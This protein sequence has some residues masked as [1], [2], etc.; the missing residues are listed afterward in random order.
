[1]SCSRYNAHAEECTGV[2]QATQA[3]VERTKVHQAA[4]VVNRSTFHCPLCPDRNMDRA[5][6]L[7]HFE[8]K[9]RR[10]AGVC[11]ICA[12]MPWGDPNYVS[13]DLYGHMKLRHK[14]DYDT[15]TDF[16][17]QE[18]AMLRKVMEDSLNQ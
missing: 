2:Q 10:A 18:E 15:Y 7:K 16:A 6:L 17:E 3:L 13:Q 5:A 14:F 4:P 12:V 9:H 8:S 11:P 1:M